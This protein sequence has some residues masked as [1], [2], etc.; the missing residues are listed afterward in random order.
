VGLAKKYIFSA[1]A[2][3]SK[4]AKDYRRTLFYSQY[5]HLRALLA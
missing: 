3:S 4:A 2:Q 5:T 1:K